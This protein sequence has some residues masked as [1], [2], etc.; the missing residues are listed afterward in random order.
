MKSR[1]KKGN[2]GEKNFSVQKVTSVCGVILTTVM[3]L[4]G[5]AAWCRSSLSVRRCAM[6]LQDARTQDCATYWRNS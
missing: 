3:I 1:L 6:W 5:I 4:A 2:Q